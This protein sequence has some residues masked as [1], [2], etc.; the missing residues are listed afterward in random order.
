M[1]SLGPEVMVLTQEHVLGVQSTSPSQAR[2]GWLIAVSPCA[3]V[4]CMLLRMVG[5]S[6]YLTC[7]IECDC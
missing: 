5:S 2:M 3:Q 7:S 4:L 6:A 1:Q